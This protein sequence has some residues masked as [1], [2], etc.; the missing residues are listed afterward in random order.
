MDGG[1]ERDSGADASIDAANS[2]GGFVAC[3]TTSVDAY[4]ATIPADIIWVIDNSTSM[5]DEERYVQ[6]NM[7]TFSTR[8]AGSGTDYR[9]I[10]ITDPGRITIP[11]PLGGSPEFLAVNQSVNSHDALQLI[12]TTYP[13]WQS[14]LRPNSIKHFVVVT[15]DESAWTPAEFRSAL[16]ALTDPGFA[17]GFVFHAIVA[18]SLG[19]SFPLGPC[20]DLAESIGSRYIELQESTSGVFASLCQSN[21]TP[22]FTQLA[23]AV[24]SLASL[25]CAFDI[26]NP[27]AGQVLDPMRLNLAYTPA[28]GDQEFIPQV[29]S[30]S[31]CGVSGGWYYDDPTSPTQVLTCPTTCTTL[32]NDMSG[33]VSIAFGC[34]TILF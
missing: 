28:G 2:D 31:E 32:A 10:M 13:R 3:E 6:T 14:F 11:P 12:V 25:P 4:G 27:P 8:I 30:E 22:V 19:L 29:P 23:E 15:D 26:P 5:R 20:Y 18:E 1:G 17:D 34:A 7:N 9:V 33:A 21:W 16:A 24:L